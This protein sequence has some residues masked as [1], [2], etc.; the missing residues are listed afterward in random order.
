MLS[1]KKNAE[2][3]DLIINSDKSLANYS[4]KWKCQLLIVSGFT[5]IDILLTDEI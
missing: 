2:T 1:Q 4:R 5:F 3:I